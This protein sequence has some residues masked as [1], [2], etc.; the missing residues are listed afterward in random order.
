MAYIYNREPTEMC[1]FIGKELRENLHAARGSEEAGFT[2]FLTHK[3][4]LL[5]TSKGVLTQ[6]NMRVP[7]VYDGD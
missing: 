3:S 7:H 5:S 2:Q 4:I 1:K 6:S